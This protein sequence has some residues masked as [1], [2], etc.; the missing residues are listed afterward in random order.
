MRANWLSKY[1][2]NGDNDNNSNN[3]NNINNNNINEPFGFDVFISFSGLVVLPAPFT[4]I[5]CVK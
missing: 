4:A 2:T 3:N 5:T 1:S